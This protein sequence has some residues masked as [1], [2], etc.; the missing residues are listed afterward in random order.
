[1]S[2]PFERLDRDEFRAYA[3]TLGANSIFVIKIRDRLIEPETIVSRPGFCRVAADGLEI[4]VEAMMTHM[5]GAPIVPAHQ[6]FKADEKP[7]PPKR[8]TFEEAVRS[9]GLTPEQQRRLLEL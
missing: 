9:S 6:H 7:S 3:A 5:R 4:P 1:V 2:N 8:E